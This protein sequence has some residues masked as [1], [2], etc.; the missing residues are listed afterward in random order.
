MVS[1]TFLR[2]PFPC[3]SREGP[4]NGT[5]VAGGAFDGR[6]DTSSGFVELGGREENEVRE[7]GVGQAQRY[8]APSRG[9]TMGSGGGDAD[10]PRRRCPDDGDRGRGGGDV[11]GG[12]RDQ[13]FLGDGVDDSG[14]EGATWCG[15]RAA[16]VLE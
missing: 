8:R 12:Q 4:G 2:A 6:R 3:C 16:Q 10:P 14:G 15:G 7:A 11:G 9:A 1:A 5:G 13:R